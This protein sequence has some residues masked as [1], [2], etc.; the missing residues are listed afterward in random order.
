VIAYQSHWL[1]KR[2]PLQISRGM[3]TGGTNLF[4]SVSDHGM[5]GWG[6][7]APGVREGAASAD[8][9]LAQLQGFVG[10]HAHLSAIHDV[11]AAARAAGVGACAL[12]AL[13]VALWD[14]HAKQAGLPLHRLLG[15]PRRS[16]VTS[17]TIGI[18]PPEVICER[19]ALALATGA[20]ALKVKL[21]S[22][23]G[24]EADQAIFEAVRNTVNAA[25]DKSIAIRVDANGGW[26]LPEARR[27]LPWLA[28][29]GAEYIEQPLPE[30]AE[31]QLPAL[32]AHRPL[33]IFV[34][35]SCRYSTDIPGWADCVD[36]VNL[37]LMKCGGV[38]EALRIV[39]TARAFGLRT[40]IGCMGESSIAIAAGASLAALFD[41][42]DLDSHLNLDP[43]PADG[44]P[45]VQ[46]VVLPAERPGHGG[47][48]NHA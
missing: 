6:E 17:L 33:P 3:I 45:F 10:D 5:T 44:A 14:L 25:N 37:K 15:L 38:T 24:I 47:R 34:D 13:D 8:E 43:D 31:D 41:Y 27:M 20:R 4:V 42:V 40:M 16:V 32:Y 46:G 19:V 21:G 39:A 35:E 11:W 18:N 29:R 48:L 7:M 1:K 9:G 36:G 30:G 28:E 2:F 23:D 12:A 22:P 26:S